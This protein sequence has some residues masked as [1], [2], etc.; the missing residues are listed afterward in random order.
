[1]V[2]FE[3]GL[4]LVHGLGKPPTALEGNLQ[5]REVQSLEVKN[6]QQIRVRESGCHS[7]VLNVIAAAGFQARRLGV[8]GVAGS[9]ACE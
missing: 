1:M 7:V 3:V 6:E 5:R 2:R 4:G 8:V 9:R